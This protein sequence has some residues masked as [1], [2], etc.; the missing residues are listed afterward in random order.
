MAPSSSPYV[1]VD[2]ILP[3]GQGIMLVSNNEARFNVALEIIRGHEGHLKSDK[4]QHVA[5]NT[6][7]SEKYKA[8]IDIKSDVDTRKLIPQLVQDI[9]QQLAN[10]S[11]ECEVRMTL[12]S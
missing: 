5:I 11:L 1:Q 6:N 10:H 12:D 3:S 4:L 7:T 2:L 9:Q 8:W